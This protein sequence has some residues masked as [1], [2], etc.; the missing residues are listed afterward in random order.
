MLLQA[1]S[2]VLWLF[3]PC[4]CILSFPWL[5]T[6]Q[7]F[8]LELWEGHGG[9]SPFLTDKEQGTQKGFHTQ[10]PTGLLDSQETDCL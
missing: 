1:C 2:V 9:W 6:V 3:L 5:A 7:I 10:E 4:P 8:P